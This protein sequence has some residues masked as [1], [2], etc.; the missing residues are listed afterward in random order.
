MCCFPKSKLCAEERRGSQNNS[1]PSFAARIKHPPL[2][3]YEGK[4]SDFAF[5]SDS[6]SLV[7]C[8]GGK[9]LIL[10]NQTHKINSPLPGG[11]TQYLMASF[12]PDQKWVLTA[13]TDFRVALHEAKTGKQM[14]NLGQLKN[15]INRAAFSPSGE[16]AAA[17]G[18]RQ[19]SE[20]AIW[21]LLD[22][23]HQINLRGPQA[24]L[25]DLQFSPDGQSMAAASGDGAVIVWDT[26]GW[27]WKVRRGAWIASNGGVM[28]LAFFPD[29]Q[30][31][32][33]AAPL[34]H[35]ITF[36]D[37]L[38]GKITG[39]IDTGKQSLFQCIAF[40]PDGRVLAVSNGG[41]QIQFWDPST[42]ATSGSLNCA[43]N[44]FRIGFSSDGRF[45]ATVTTKGLLLWSIADK[46][47][48]VPD[49]RL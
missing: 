47:Q 9:V 12:S 1:N 21:D 44:A 16:F 49:K 23:T 10:D 42:L 5:S 2:N 3:V 30:Q 41:A 24:T 15:P 18:G 43:G 33:A 36:L 13:D 38:T 19:E 4:V 25:N 35:Q 26:T 11:T 46:I 48:Q 22:A 28:S 17:V 14:K 7:F 27:K 8:A 39:Q 20:L 34:E 6:S 40:S 31:L 32:A 45:L 37:I 29:G